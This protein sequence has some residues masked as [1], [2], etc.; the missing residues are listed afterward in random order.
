MSTWRNLKGIRKYLK[1]SKNKNTTFQNLFD[2]SK[3]CSKREVYS[4]TG[5]PQ[6]T[7]KIR[8]KQPNITC[9]VICKRIK[10]KVTRKTKQN[11]TVSERE[12]ITEKQKNNIE[13]KKKK[14][15]DQWNQELFFF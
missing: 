3:N 2:G 15:K 10:P 8:N 14:K 1:T 4:D 7:R 5:L 12:W 13:A 6:E 11:K 9:K